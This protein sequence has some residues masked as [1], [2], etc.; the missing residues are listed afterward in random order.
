MI[1]KGRMMLRLGILIPVSF[2]AFVIMFNQHSIPRANLGVHNGKLAPCPDSPNCVC[3][4]STDAGH[5]IEPL[6]YTKSAAEAM[7]VLKE[8]V[9]QQKRTTIITETTNY[10][11]VE[12]RSALFRFVD[13]VEFLVEDKVIQVRSASRVGYSDLGV[14]RK[15]VETIRR[16]FD[17]RQR[18]GLAAS[19]RLP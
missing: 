2:V 1:K 3:S 18:S 7:V 10:L 6:R 15:R 19:P 17:V 12:F 9:Q 14:N 11:H 16:E 5:L 8:V 13:D 4:Q